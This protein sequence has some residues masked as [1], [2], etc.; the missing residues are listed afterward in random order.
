MCR[1]GADYLLRITAPAVTISSI[2]STQT[3][4]STTSTAF[5]TVTSLTTITA[6]EDSTST[7]K[8]KTPQY[9]QAS[10][11][12]IW[13]D[14]WPTLA[15]SKKQDPSSPTNH[16]RTRQVLWLRTSPSEI[17]CTDSS[18]PTCSHRRDRYCL[19]H[20]D[21]CNHVSGH[22]HGLHHDYSDSLHI[23]ISPRAE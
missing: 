12:A 3:V 4:T 8:R 10:R 21:I 17:V 7:G 13:I 23:R 14:L 20:R 5:E 16:R 2:V 15:A 11:K 19:V 22:E 6:V 18:T 9:P 1:I